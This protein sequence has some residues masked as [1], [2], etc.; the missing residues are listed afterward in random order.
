MDAK[1]TEVRSGKRLVQAAV[2][3]A[4][5]IDLQGPKRILGCQFKEGAENLEH[6]KEFERNLLDR[7]LRRMLLFM[8]DAF[9]GLTAVTEGM[10]PQYEVQ[11]CLPSSPGPDP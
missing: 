10:F 1:H 9:S 7:D 2:H 5:G 11:L 8:Q 3:T 4:L 6:R